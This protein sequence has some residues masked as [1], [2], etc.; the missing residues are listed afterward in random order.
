MAPGDSLGDTWPLLY[1]WLALV[2]RCVLML[3][4]SQVAAPTH[5]MSVRRYMVSSL[6]EN[7]VPGMSMVQENMVWSE[8]RSVDRLVLTVTSYM[9]PLLTVVVVTSL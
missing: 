9:R 8:S 7:W 3:P 1:T 5:L 6:R 2:L 4:R